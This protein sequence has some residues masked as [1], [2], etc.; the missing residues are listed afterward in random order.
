MLPYTPLHHL[1]FAPAPGHEA[2]P[3]A[4]LVMTSGNLGDEPICYDDTDACTRLRGIAD[5][6]LLHNRPIHV[7]CDDSVVRAVEGVEQPV[8]RSRGHSPA[9]ITLVHDAPPLLAVGGDLKNAFCLASRRTA[10]MSQHLGDM[11]SVETLVAFERSVEQFRAMYRVDPELLVTDLHPGYITRRWAEE[12]TAE[13]LHVQHHHAHAAALMAE[14]GVQRDAAVVAC[15]FDGTGYGTDGSVWGG[16]VLVARYESFERAGH[17]RTIRIPGGDAGV[18]SPARIAL[19]PLRAAGM[20]WTADLPPVLALSSDVRAVLD[21]QLARQV[22]CANTSSIGRLFDAVS[23]L[24][25][26]RHLSSYEGQAAMELEAAAVDADD[27]GPLLACS[28]DGGVIDPAPLLRALIAAR[29]SGAT[30]ASLARA[31]HLAVADA[32]VAAV[33]RVS[34]A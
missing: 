8:R 24:L 34:E 11:G 18:R 27:D 4:V 32:I 33:T 12:R 6:W 23:S 13:A 7:P 19:A 1:L 22:A 26:I 21:R 25:G 15:A 17:L 31:F 14:H 30:V 16:E 20:P 29:R 28:I 10:W 3:P 9:P 5:A 2:V